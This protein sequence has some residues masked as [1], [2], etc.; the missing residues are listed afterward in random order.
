[1]ELTDG[2]RL[3]LE[4]TARR[5]LPAALRRK[6]LAMLHLAEGCPLRQVAALLRVT[7]RSVYQW[8]GRYQAAGIAGW[9]LRPGRGRKAR[10]DLEQ[11]KD[12]LRQSPRNF[13]LARTRWTLAALAQVVPSLRGFSPFGVQQALRRAGISYKR[14]QP[15]LHSPDPQYQEEKGLWSEH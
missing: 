11:L 12:Y 14:G 10:A 3:E 1:M 6:A 9:R 13:G 4:L 7:R 8:R 15:L 2:Q 5:G